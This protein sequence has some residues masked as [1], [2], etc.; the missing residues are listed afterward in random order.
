MLSKHSSFSLLSMYTIYTM[1][2]TSI[3]QV[4]KIA[5]LGL[6]SL[7]NPLISKCEN[8]KIFSEN[9]PHRELSLCAT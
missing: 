3:E 7:I 9:F 1:L 2:C 5:W 4:L 8:L 6:Y